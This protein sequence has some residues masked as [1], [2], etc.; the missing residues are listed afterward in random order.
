MKQ[1][2]EQ[3]TNLF[4]PISLT[5]MDS[6]ALM[7]RV[8]T[9]F[10][11]SRKELIYTLNS[12]ATEYRILEIDENRIMM[13]NSLYFDTKVKTFY[14]NHHNGKLNRT[15]VRIRKY[16]DSNLCFLEVKQKDSKGNT[17]KSRIRITDFETK[18]S[19]KSV[20]F[21]TDI[22]GVKYKLFPSIWNNFNRIT[23]V[24]IKNKERVTIDLNLNFTIGASEKTYK[25][26]V[27]VELK[28]KSYDRNS[29]IVKALR[30]HRVHPY[31]ISKYC[32][33]MV[34]LYPGLKY[35]KF[36]EKLIKINKISV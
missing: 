20:T 5:E 31:S 35:N 4:H 32:I 36:K 18:L 9:K 1:S 23:L 29:S 19:N 22:T 17:N 14:H 28:Q 8:D 33:G 34:N 26:T 27:I 30:K 25:D 15:K 11:T 10:I 24:S 16:V 13:Y 3:L 21:I 6:V 2:I 7:K 12:I